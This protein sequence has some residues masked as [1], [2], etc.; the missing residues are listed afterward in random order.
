M[1]L[2]SSLLSIDIGENLLSTDIPKKVI[3]MLKENNT[4]REFNLGKINEEEKVRHC[5][6]GSI[7]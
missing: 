3:H 6:Y 1:L 5:F 7:L 2:N 4:L